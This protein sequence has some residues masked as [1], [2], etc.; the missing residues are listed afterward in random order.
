MSNELIR[1]CDTNHKPYYKLSH[2][3]DK[4]FPELIILC[5]SKCVDWSPYNKLVREPI[6][7]D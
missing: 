1:V 4:L 6:Q 7:N 3:N 2:K 5:C